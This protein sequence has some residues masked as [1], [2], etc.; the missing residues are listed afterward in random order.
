[1]FPRFD[2][3][4]HLSDLPDRGRILVAPL[5]WGIGHATRCIPLI[6]QLQKV[7]YQPVIASDGEALIL[8]RKTFPL[9]PSFELPSYNVLYAKKPIW[10][11]MRLLWQL[12]KFIKT[13]FK[14]KRLI[15]KIV[16][17]ENIAAIISDNRFGV[18]YSAISSIYISH[19]LT[20]KAGLWTFLTTAIHKNLI[21]KF[22]K[23]WVPDTAD[24]YNL[25][26]ELSHHISILT[27]ISFIGILSQFEKVEIVIKYDFLVLLSGPEPQRSML[28]RD[29]LYQLEDFRKKVC[30]VKG[31]IENKVERIQKGNLTIYNYLLKDDLQLIINQSNLIIARSGYSTIMDLAVLQKKCFFI[32]TS[33]QTEQIYLA[34]HLK[35]ERIAPYVAQSDFSLS[36]LKQV[37]NYRGFE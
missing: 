33:G 12:P 21:R 24:S 8:L 7:G 1:M 22:D 35:K 11:L 36:L 2:L 20:V 19:Q 30:F 23:C 17:E 27:P 9:L 18:S 14:E 10:F 16:K 28:E 4:K 25:S 6:S 15:K 29:L 26:G 34:K 31:V 3:T 32:P 5:N 13:Y 37:E